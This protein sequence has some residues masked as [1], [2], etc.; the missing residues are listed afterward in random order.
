LLELHELIVERVE[1]DDPLALLDFFSIPRAERGTAAPHP[2]VGRPADLPPSKPKPF[3]IEKRK[4][5]F[6]ILPSR[7][8]DG[9]AYPLMFRVRCAYDVL[10]G[11]PFKRF[12]DLDF[13][14]F[15]AHRGESRAGSALSIITTN[16]DCWQ[17]EPN[18]LD[19]KAN[20]PNFK[21]EVVG[22]DPNRDIVIEAQS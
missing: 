3:R 8:I 15:K 7:P 2:T 10:S 16:A 14:L 1:R 22:F 11:N 5:G 12:S 9:F 4:G 13:D 21:V 17:T 6:A 19:I 18:Q 20:G